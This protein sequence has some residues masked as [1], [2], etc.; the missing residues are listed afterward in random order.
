MLSRVAPDL[1]NPLF[2]RPARYHHMEL[3]V[4]RHLVI[5]RGTPRH[6]STDRNTQ[7]G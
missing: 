5:S 7:K 6:P 3:M 1:D 2:G 4:S